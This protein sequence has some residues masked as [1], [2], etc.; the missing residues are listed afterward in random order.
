MTLTQKD[1]DAIGDLVGLAIDESLEKKLDE[2]LKHF[3]TKEGFF[4]KMDEVMK[5]L[6][7][8]REDTIVL[9]SQ[10]ERNTEKIE[11]TESKT[12]LQTS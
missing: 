6:K 4:N 3:P 10:V 2:K 5:E 8:I 7:D 1:L 11:T 9:K 12:L